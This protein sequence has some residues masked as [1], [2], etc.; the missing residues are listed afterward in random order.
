M[1]SSAAERRSL[2]KRGRPI[3]LDKR[4]R[5]IDLDKRGRPIALED[6]GSVQTSD[7]AKIMQLQ[8]LVSTVILFL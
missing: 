5:P 3:D 2:S 4:G 7:T 8:E 1:L 6:Y